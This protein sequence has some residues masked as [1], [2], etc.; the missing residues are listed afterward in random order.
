ME[1]I[2]K[3]ENG[4][5]IIFNGGNPLPGCPKDWDEA[6]EI[7]A[8]FNNNDGRQLFVDYEEL[9]Y[10]KW[11]FDCGFKLDFD[12]GIFKI[13][14]RFYPPTS[15]GGDKWDGNAHLE[16]L[17]KRVATK[18]FECATVDELRNEV[19]QYVLAVAQKLDAI[20]WTMP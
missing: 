6:C 15:H 10:P 20:D 12:G 4:T 17:G 5:T 14:S 13:S 16:I 8:N 7:E 1:N 9:D 11:R 2:L 3:F 19:D 18:K